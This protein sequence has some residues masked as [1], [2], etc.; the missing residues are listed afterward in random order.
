MQF[1]L[2]LSQFFL[3]LTCLSD[4]LS[5]LKVFTGT[6]LLTG[7]VR[8]SRNYIEV[9]VLELKVVRDGLDVVVVRRHLL[10]LTSRQ[11]Y[12]LLLMQ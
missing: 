11:F 4:G 1:G 2:L 8:M 3:L 7:L 5:V 9:L 12:H 6:G 10:G